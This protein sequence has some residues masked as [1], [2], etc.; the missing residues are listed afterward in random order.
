LESSPFFS[1]QTTG[2]GQVFIKGDSVTVKLDSGQMIGT[3][4]ITN[5][6]PLVHVQAGIASHNKKN[7]GWGI[8]ALSTPQLLNNPINSRDTLTIKP[9][10]TTFNVPKDILKDDHWVI[11]QITVKNPTGR[12]A[13]LFS[14]EPEHLGCRADHDH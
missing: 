9:F 11:L 5:T 12:N 1:V 2:N 3:E 13:L 7:D 10:E 14:H 4:K 6:I 8:S